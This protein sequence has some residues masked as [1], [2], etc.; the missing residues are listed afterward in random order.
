MLTHAKQPQYYRCSDS[1]TDPSD[2]LDNPLC[3]VMLH[4]MIC[5][6]YEEEKTESWLPA[7]KCSIALI[8]H[9]WSMRTAVFVFWLL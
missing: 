3:V 5:S 4:N 7:K 8:V 6:A 2:R 9:Q 1:W